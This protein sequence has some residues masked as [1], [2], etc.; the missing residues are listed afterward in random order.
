M[1][2][3]AESA[4]MRK[5]IVRWGAVLAAGAAAMLLTLLCG[6]ALAGCIGITSPSNG[7]QVSGSAVAIKTSDNCSGVW[8]EGLQVNGVAAGAFATGQ[9]VFDSTTVANGDNVISVTSQSENPGS[10]VL[11]SASITLKVANGS[12]IATVA[13]TP[14][15]EP[16]PTPTATP[17]HYS[18]RG[19]GAVLPAEAA[20]ASQV[21]ATP[22]RENAAWNEDDGTGYNSNQPP[23]GGVPAY[24][25]AN[26]PCCTELPNADFA[27][28][29]G[30]YGG[31]SDDIFRVYA[32]KW[33]IDE[34]YVRAEAW[35]ESEWHQ[36]CA[37]AH[38]GSG[39]NEAG[40]LNNPS[41]CSTGLKVTTITP[42]GEFCALQGFGGLA[43]PSQ[44]ASWSI[45]QT[46]V[47]YNWMTWPMIEE[48][49]P[50][51][52]DYRLAEMRGCVNGDQ[53]G[54][55]EAQ[56]ATS[57]GDYRDAVNA[58]QSN[59][60]GWS[61]IAGW[62]NLQYLAYGCIDAHYSGD[63]FSGSSDSY[64]GEF[65]NALNTAPWPGGQ[66]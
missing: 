20:C 43:S 21:D 42:N 45:F 59:P 28:V 65:L 4:P 8:F 61:K 38:G 46:K 11:G 63:W 51:A 44:Y 58:A 7:A 47:Y 64:L 32:C 26:A 12:A 55:F 27:G 14:T 3:V 17:V 52:V 5:L 48:S 39:C 22:S 33:G 15:L 18:M 57:A 35:V 25:Y 1:G 29:D 41:G 34:D 19:P 23:P 40:D 9:V 16:T 6:H 31:T 49:T 2:C 24:F 56:S 36:D 60:N 53:Y 13:P 10:K 62:T 30:T 54:Y 66:R 37:A 50:F